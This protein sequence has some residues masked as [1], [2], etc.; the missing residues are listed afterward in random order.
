MN[1]RAFVLALV[2]MGALAAACGGDLPMADAKPSPEALA[3]GVLD[4]LERKDRPALEALALS[5]QEFRAY[6]WPDLPAARPERNL[7]FSYVWGDLRTKSRASLGTTLAAHGGRRYELIRVHFAGEAT[8]Y[9][10]SEVRRDTVLTVRD[11]EG[12]E[13]E[14]RLYGSS[15]RQGDGWK[16]FS[17]VV[18]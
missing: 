18:D 9:S 8:R 11:S 6:V 14:L 4:A 17:Y 15:L 2:G 5:E 3:R 7:P 1:R 10:R 12:V 16:V 13:Q